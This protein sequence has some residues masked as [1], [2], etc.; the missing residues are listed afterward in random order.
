MNL[1]RRTVLTGVAA[2]AAAA[3]LS[4]SP[5]IAAPAGSGHTGPAHLAS[6]RILLRNGHVIDTEPQAVAHAGTDVLIERGRITAVG[7]NLRAGNAT[8]IDATDRIVLPGFVDTHRHVWL[9]ALRTS[10]VGLDLTAYLGVLGQYGPRLRPQDMYNATLAGLLESLN[11]GVTTQLDYNHGL[12]SPDHADAALDAMQAAGLRAVFAYGAP[13]GAA[14]DLADVRRVRTERL[15][16]DK[17]L[18]TLAYGPLGPSFAPIE[19]VIEEWR[20][21]DELS[22]P[23]TFHVSAGPVTQTPIS[24]LKERGLLRPNTL[25]VHGNSLSDSEIKLIGD[26]GGKAAAAPSSEAGMRVGAPVSSRYRRLGVTAGLGVDAVSSVPGDMFSL[27]RAALLASQVTDDSPLTAK[28]VLRM[29]T[30]DGAS[31]LGLDDRIGSLR[32]GKQADVVLLRLED[33]DMLTAERDPIAAVVQSANPHNVDTVIV[34]GR[35]MKSAG[36]LLHADLR[37]TARA[38]RSTAAAIS[39]N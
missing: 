31:A 36:R 9:S 25:Y 38:L 39:G 29:A 28:D 16:D 12:Y 24:A 3:T 22:L 19:T 10:T 35:V 6:G 26:S 5:A 27:M 4:S 34:A 33:L 23:L 18:V 7:R 14:A 17:A 20:V 8:V 37:R 13:I 32:P 11:S 30:I 21:T 15:F 2:T 1:P